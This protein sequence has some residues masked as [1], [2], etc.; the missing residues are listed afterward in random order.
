MGVHVIAGIN[1]KLDKPEL[2]DGCETRISFP[3]KD[4]L[5]DMKFFCKFSRELPTTGDVWFKLGYSGKVKPIT[6]K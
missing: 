6:L 5:N 4:K 3:T 2:F 1:F